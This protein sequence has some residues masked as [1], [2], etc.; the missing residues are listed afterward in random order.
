M[1]FAKTNK[2]LD[3]TTLLYNSYVTLS[4]IPLETYEYI[5]NGKAALDWIIERYQVDTN[6]DSGI[7]NDPNDWSED[8]RYIL[9]LVKRVVRVSVETVRI[10]KGLPGLLE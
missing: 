7:K 5:V 8:P 10:V 6:K 9:E 1:T 4:G 2:V 3:K